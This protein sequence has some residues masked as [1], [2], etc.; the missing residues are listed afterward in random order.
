MSNTTEEYSFENLFISADIFLDKRLTVNEK[1]IASILDNYRNTPINEIMS[2]LKC[3]EKAVR[4][5][6]KKLQNLGYLENITLNNQQIL[7]KKELKC[8]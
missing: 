6:M 2:F 5:S 3:S 1:F 7:E 8:G 4:K